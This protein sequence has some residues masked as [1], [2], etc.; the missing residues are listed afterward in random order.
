MLFLCCSI[1]FLSTVKSQQQYDIT[2]YFEH[3]TIPITAA[4]TFSN[5]L[6]ITNHTEKTIALEA[7]SDHTIALKGLVKLPQVMTIMPNDKRVFPLKYMAD[8]QTI[9]A[10]LQ[11]F[12]VGLTS[13]D[14]S[15]SIQP[16]QSFC[17]VLQVQ[18][19][20]LVETEQQ[21]YY[22][23]QATGQVQFIVRTAN[24]GLVPLTF[25][26]RFPNLTPEL[27]ITGETLPTTLSAGAQALLTYTATMRARKIANDV[28]LTVQ[29]I[30]A[31]GKV[32]ASS[33]IRIIT[34]GSIKRFD[35]DVN[36]LNQTYNNKV[37]LRYLTLGQDMSVYQLQGYGKLELN[38]GRRLDYRVN[39]DY[40]KELRGVNLYDTYVDYQSDKW[41][42]KLGNI[43]ENMDQFIN[44]RGIQ[45]RYKVDKGKSISLYAVQNNYMLA[46]QLIRPIPGGE[47]FGA[48]YDFR[49]E[50]NQENSIIYL[51]NKNTYRGVQS[52]LVY[53]KSEVDLGSGQ[54]M[55]WEAGMSNEQTEQG[56]RKYGLAAGLNYSGTFGKYQIASMNY[57]SSP[58]YAGLRRGLTQTDS[59]I[60]MNLTA[61]KNLS[62]R[63]SYMDNSPTYMQGDRNYFFDYTNRIQIYELGYHT[64][65]GKL[66]LNVRPYFMGQRSSYPPWFGLVN[67]RINWTSSSVRTVADL[68]FFSVRHRFLLQTDYGY[69]YKNSSHRPMAPFHSLRITGNYNNSIF[70]FNTLIQVN[71]Y[72][73]SDLLATNDHSSYRMLSLGPNTQFAALNQ[74]LR[75]QFATMYSYYGF[76]KSN[77][78]SVNGNARWQLEGGWSLTADVFYTFISVKPLINAALLGDPTGLTT[79]SYS[80]NNRQIRLGVEKDFGRRGG[81]KGYIVQLSFFEDGN[82]NGLQDRN[83]SYAKAMLV[84]IG[85]ET[86]MT[87]QK[88]QVKFVD[89]EAGSYTVQVENNQGWVSQGPLHIVLTKNQRVE[90][91]LVKTSKLNGHIQVVTKKY[92]ETKPALSGIKVNAV[93][94]NGKSYSTM[95]NEEGNYVLYVPV[96]IYNVS[97]N[98]EGMP[99]SIENPNCE[100]EVK[101]GQPIQVPQFRYRDER[102]KM[103]IKRF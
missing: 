74:R 57:Y 50:C 33:R 45:A 80:F 20:L 58:Y 8:R 36:L 16:H 98:T 30:E 66:Q 54:S 41:G 69:T 47:V 28:D 7:S 37:A 56:Q 26:L 75:A 70:G 29:A 88:G 27:E 97:I 19:P 38:A 84:K 25:Q 83:E 64:G 42:I 61:H 21:E 68:N 65:M 12:V 77:N 49:T 86:A 53:G 39:L 32:V 59:R 40:Y 60:T 62:A 43:Y 15:I 1:V 46:S 92:M 55:L 24:V 67:D 13:H 9:S 93:D 2:Y 76:S 85:K 78:L 87:D 96:G 63:I 22:I 18:H 89:M 6:I 94:Q 44:G 4:N 3:D 73:L 34:V 52:N 51:H 48:K 95:S 11:V 82:N 31:G 102:R 100:I 17:T 91:P 71:P 10:A 35:S 103:E 23:N 5:K 99:F 79:A 81:R 72:Y 14:D 101:S 90:M